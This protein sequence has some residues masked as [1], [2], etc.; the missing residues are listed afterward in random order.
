MVDK[1]RPEERWKYS[2][3]EDVDFRFCCNLFTAVKNR[4]ETRDAF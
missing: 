3:L 2:T 1:R 4:F